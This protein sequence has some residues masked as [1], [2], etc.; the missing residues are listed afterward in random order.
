MR[1]DLSVNVTFTIRDGE[2][3][4]ELDDELVSENENE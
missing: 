2:F 1:G 3:A 4:N